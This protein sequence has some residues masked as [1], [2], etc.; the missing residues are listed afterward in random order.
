MLADDLIQQA[1]NS[2]LPKI[3]LWNTFTPLEET[4][5]PVFPVAEVVP[6]GYADEPA[7]SGSRIETHRFKLTIADRS[8]SKVFDIARSAKAAFE[9]IDSREL[10]EAAAEISDFATPW[11]GGGRDIFWELELTITLQI[12]VKGT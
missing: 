8:R 3:R 4:E 2:V 12:F 7:L 6:S 10:V 1:W 5:S 11:D 9:A